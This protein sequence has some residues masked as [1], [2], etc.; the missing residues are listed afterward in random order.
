M[1]EIF[2]LLLS[3]LKR[4]IEIGVFE[5]LR[6][7]GWKVWATLLLTFVVL[8]GVVIILTLILLAVLF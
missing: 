2:D 3:W 8:I 7:V 1:K 4:I 5:F 6:K